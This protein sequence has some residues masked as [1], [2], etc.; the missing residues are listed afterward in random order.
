MS[1]VLSFSHVGYPYRFHQ[2]ISML[3]KQLQCIQHLN[4]EI[5]PGR[6]TTKE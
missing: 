6:N 1:H 3:G 4:A 5:R 2:N